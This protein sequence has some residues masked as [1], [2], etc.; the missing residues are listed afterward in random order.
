VAELAR[1]WRK[2]GLPEYDLWPKDSHFHSSD[3]KKLL[4]YL[5]VLSAGHFCLWASDGRRR[6]GM[7]KSG[8]K[9]TGFFGYALA[10]KRFFENR[11][12]EAT[13]E[14]FARISLREFKRMVGGGGGLQMLER[15]W[16]VLRAV[17]K[18]FLEGYDS[19]P[20]RFV[21][22]ARGKSSKL[23]PKIAKELPSFDD[24][25]GS[26]VTNSKIYFWKRAQILVGDIHLAFH[27]RG[28]G[29]FSDLEYLT[30]LADY[31]LPQ[32][33]NYWGILE[34]DAELADKIR[35]KRCLGAGCREEVEIRST[36]IWAI[37]YLKEELA[38][39]GIER[40]S[41]EID[42]LVWNESKRIKMPAAHHRTRTI[43]Y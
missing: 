34:Y 17:S 21:E 32:I 14:Y 36:A 28:L 15:R 37:E 11:P 25:V 13:F 4:T 8:K 41:L 6:W 43:Y 40:T 33:L 23:V 7:I 12:H 5:I 35:Q 38:K 20:T 10:L 42:W 9:I 27:R 16:E 29:S 1:R 39:L 31:K 24:S 2:K 18:V 19:D 30:A 3:A 26:D 22:L